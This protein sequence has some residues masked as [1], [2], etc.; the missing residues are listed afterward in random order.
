MREILGLVAI[1]IPCERDMCCCVWPYP[2]PCLS[3]A[4]ALFTAN[5]SEAP[6]DTVKA[7][8]DPVRLEIRAPNTLAEGDA[9]TMYNLLKGNMHGMYVKAGWGWDESEKWREME[10]RDARFLIARCC[11]DDGGSG[12]NIVRSSGEEDCLKERVKKDGG[13][14]KASDGLEAEEG[15]TGGVATG[16]AGGSTIASTLAGRGLACREKEDAGDRLA[17]YC[18]FR[19]AWDM[20]DNEDGEGA[21][22]TDDVLYV[23]EL[24]VAPWAKRRGLGRRMM[25]ALEVRQGVS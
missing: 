20:D 2:E 14:V 18:H 6:P 12:D 13:D 21:G 5:S 15:K 16:Q 11:S 3:L 4:L 8:P 1:T 22:G 7:T 17:G 25:Q 24:Q 9:Q 19:F 10:H 23:Y